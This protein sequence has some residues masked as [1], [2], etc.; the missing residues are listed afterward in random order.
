MV[1][2][3]ISAIKDDQIVVF[4]FVQV[5]MDVKLRGHVGVRSLAK[6]SDCELRAEVKCNL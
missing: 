3:P 2:R 5:E 6:G 1:T 4:V